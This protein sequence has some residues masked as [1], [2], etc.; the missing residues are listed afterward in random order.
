MKLVLGLVP[1][2]FF[3]GVASVEALESE[4]SYLIQ[5]ENIDLLLDVDINGNTHVSDIFIHTDKKDY[6]FDGTK[7]YTERI[8]S[9]GDKGRIFAT[10][11]PSA[12]VYIIYDLTNENMLV[13]LWDDGEKLRLKVS[14]TNIESLLY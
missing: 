3:I 4:Q 8:E 14:I 11:T 7:K 1:L 10:L 2:L 13:A 6:S 5:T 9:D 12:K